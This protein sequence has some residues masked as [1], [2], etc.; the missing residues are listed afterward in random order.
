MSPVSTVTREQS[1]VRTAPKPP[2]P[3][4]DVLLRLAKEI[5]VDWQ[6]PSESDRSS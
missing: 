6:L 2:Y 5:V 3:P 1:G 4:R